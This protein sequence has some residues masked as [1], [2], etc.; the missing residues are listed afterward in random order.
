MITKLDATNVPDSDSLVADVRSYRPG[1]SV[2]LT[3]RSQAGGVRNVTL[4]LGSD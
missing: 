3:I 2:T 1:D 4:T